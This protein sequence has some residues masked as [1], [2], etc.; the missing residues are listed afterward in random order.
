MSFTTGQFRLAATPP[1]EHF[2]ISWP[3]VALT[4]LSPESHYAYSGLASGSCDCGDIALPPFLW[5][6]P[7][8]LFAACAVAIAPDAEILISGNISSPVTFGLRNPVI[9]LPH[10]FAGLCR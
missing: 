3:M 10:R 8:D 6:R 2:V 5:N 1:P 7:T 9:L 4:V